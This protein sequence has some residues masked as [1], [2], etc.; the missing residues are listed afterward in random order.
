MHLIAAGIP[1]GRSL[2]VSFASFCS[3]TVYVVLSTVLIFSG[4]SAFA[5]VLKKVAKFVAVLFLSGVLLYLHFVANFMKMS[6]E[7]TWT[8]GA[9][10]LFRWVMYSTISCGVKRIFL[11]CCVFYCFFVFAMMEVFPLEK[12][13]L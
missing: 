2:V 1:R 4:I 8:P 11:H 12:I 9:L 6:I 10:P 13:I 5:M 3:A 7:S